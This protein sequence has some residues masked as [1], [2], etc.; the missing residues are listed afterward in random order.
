[1]LLLGEKEEE[2]PSSA[3]TATFDTPLGHLHW[4]AQAFTHFEVKS[5]LGTPGIE[6]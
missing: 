5:P 1:M 4:R 6:G 2:G 3:G